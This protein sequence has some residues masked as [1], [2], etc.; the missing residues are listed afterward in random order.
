VPGLVSLHLLLRQ[1][2]RERVAE[3][4]HHEHE[5]E[6]CGDRHHLERIK[7]RVRGRTPMMPSR[8]HPETVLA[9]PTQITDATTATSGGR[10]ART[11]SGEERR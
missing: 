7:P 9:V 3:A 1:P 8:S 10:A 4:D 6:S 2:D 5:R 11:G